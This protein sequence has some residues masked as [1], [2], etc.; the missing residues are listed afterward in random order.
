MTIH[1]IN[2]YMMLVVLEMEVVNM[3]NFYFC[4]VS[5]LQYVE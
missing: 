5:M 4:A 2:I 1:S 3:I